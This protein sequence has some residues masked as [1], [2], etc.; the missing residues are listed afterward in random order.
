MTAGDTSGNESGNSNEASAVVTSGS[1]GSVHVASISVST[2]KRGQRYEG[3]AEV[4]IVDQNGVAVS[5][6]V[7]NGSWTLN[8]SG[9]GNSSGTTDGTGTT[10]VKSAKQSASSGDEFAFTV[11]GV[12]AAGATY[13]AGANVETSDSAVVP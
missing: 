3:R 6:A 2:V 10:S 4:V 1:G 11:G 7:I 9:I 8:G 5:G 13:D 12:S